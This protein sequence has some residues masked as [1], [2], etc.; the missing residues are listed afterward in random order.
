MVACFSKQIEVNALIIVHLHK[1]RQ[2][3]IYES[4]QLQV[5]CPLKK[6]SYKDNGLPTLVNFGLVFYSIK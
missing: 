6:I 1:H 3:F 4:M 5:A 2:V